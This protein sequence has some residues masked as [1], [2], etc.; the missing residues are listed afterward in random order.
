MPPA[1]IPEGRT[2]RLLLRP[3]A[4]DDAPQIQ[5][6]FPQWEIVKYLAAK[7]PWPYP[8]DGAEQFIR[9]SALPQLQRGEAWHWTIRLLT[10]PGAI[11]GAIGLIAGEEENRGFWLAPQHR[12]HGYM[13]EAC[14][15]AN[16]FW[17]DTLGQRVLR[18]PKAIANRASR[19]ISERM[20]MR[21]VEL[22][23]RDLVSGSLPSEIW[24]I[25]ADEWRAWKQSRTGLHPARPAAKSRQ[26]APAAAQ[27]ST[28]KSRSPSRKRG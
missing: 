3:I 13:T 15:W 1:T 8:P 5:R 4:L 27:P 10:D 28:S 14:A 2:A 17:F 12:G 18:A 11:I 9:N 26:P 19:R 25:T 16:D 23:E 22:E 20:G 6:L 21:I 7:V 24:E